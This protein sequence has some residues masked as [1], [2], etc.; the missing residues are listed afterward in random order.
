MVRI[1]TETGKGV[2]S[3]ENDLSKL[4]HNLIKKKIDDNSSRKRRAQ[5]EVVLVVGC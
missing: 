3:K 1:L 2:T 5:T 4:T